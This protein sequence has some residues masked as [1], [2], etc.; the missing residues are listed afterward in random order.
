MSELLPLLRDVAEKAGLEVRRLAGESQA[1]SGLV[2]VK[3]KPVLMIFAGESAAKEEAAY[4]EALK[5]VDLSG[6]FVPPAVR[7][8]LERG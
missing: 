4:L 6:V 8:A 1:R 7:D 5:A 3:G 2:R